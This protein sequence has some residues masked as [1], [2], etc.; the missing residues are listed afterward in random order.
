MGM[1]LAEI[2]KQLHRA[3]L[4][5]ADDEWWVLSENHHWMMKASSLPETVMARTEPNLTVNSLST[6]VKKLD[7]DLHSTW[8]VLL[9]DRVLLI[10][11]ATGE[12][13]GALYVP[14]PGQ[15]SVLLGRGTEANVLWIQLYGM[16]F[17]YEKDDAVPFRNEQTG[18][19]TLIR[20]E[21]ADLLNTCAHGPDGFWYALGPLKEF[22]VRNEDGVRYAMCMPIRSDLVLKYKVVDA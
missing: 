16:K 5:Y 17:A 13:A 21:F 18:E 7:P 22:Q 9:S 6:M 3:Q 2:Y 19:L 8:W 11:P 10:I 15:V 4:V 12:R 1:K 20:Q 14:T